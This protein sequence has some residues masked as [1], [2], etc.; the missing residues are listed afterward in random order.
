MP[1]KKALSNSV[2]V[3]DLE[4]TP[5]MIEAG[6]SKLRALIGDNRWIDGD[7]SVVTAIFSEMFGASPH[8]EL[9]GGDIS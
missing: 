5:E 6:V 8:G 3:N 7:E 9:S 1:N 2:P 4:I